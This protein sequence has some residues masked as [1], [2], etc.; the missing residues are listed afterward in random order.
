MPLAWT[1]T[2]QAPSL[3]RTRGSPITLRQPQSMPVPVPEPAMGRGAH[4]ITGHRRTLSRCGC[5]PCKPSSSSSSSSN[6]RRNKHSSSRSGPQPR[7][8]RATFP[9]MRHG[10]P[11]PIHRPKG[12]SPNRTSSNTASRHHIQAIRNHRHAPIPRHLPGS[13]RPYTEAMLPVWINNTCMSRPT[14]SPSNCEMVQVARLH[15]Q[16]KP[17]TRPTSSKLL[18]AWQV[19]TSTPHSRRPTVNPSKSCIRTRSRTRCHH[20]LSRLPPSR[21]ISNRNAPARLSSL[22]NR[23]CSSS[24]S[25]FNN[26]NNTNPSPSPSGH[27]HLLRSSS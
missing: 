27:S 25:N 13:D 4:S 16:P 24:S 8:A 9:A 5:Q 6:H 17:G 12:L 2:V 3:A 21:L 11:H 20:H 26:N 15:S 14:S 19:A 23:P 1:S 10:R 7:L 18:K 22:P